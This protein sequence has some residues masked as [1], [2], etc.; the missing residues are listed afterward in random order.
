VTDAV[1]RRAVEAG[2]WTYLGVFNDNEVARRLYEELG[3][4]TLGGPS[5][6]LLLRA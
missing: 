3:F 2:A 4:V 6:D 5:P 1:T